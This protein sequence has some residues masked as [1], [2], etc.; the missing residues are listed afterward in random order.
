MV[1][2][3]VDIKTASIMR[4]WRASDYYEF[5]LQLRTTT[6]G[7]EV[8]F[9]ILDDMNDPAGLFA[10]VGTETPTGY[11]TLVDGALDEEHLTRWLTELAHRL[12]QAGV[13][14]S[15]DI[16]R[17][18]T[19]PKFVLF[20]RPQPTAFLALTLA[21]R[22]PETAPVHWSVSNEATVEVCDVAQDWLQPGGNK[23]LLQRGTFTIKTSD[24][25]KIA[26]LLCAATEDTQAAA[27]VYDDRAKRARAVSMY[28]LGQVSFQLV[29]GTEAWQERLAALRE[30]LLTFPHLL[31]QAFIRAG[32]A[33][34][35]GWAFEGLM[36][37]PTIR[38]SDFI[39]NRH[40][41]DRWVP[42]AHGIQILSDE[43]LARAN[44]LS[45]WNITD[46]GHSRHLVE[47][48]DLAPW[49]SELRP[50]P[51]TVEQARHDFGDMIVTQQEVEDNWPAWRPPRSRRQS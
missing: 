39:H 28:R 3:S 10:Q 31:D 42:D 19:K 40:L 16:T 23:V 15:L 5:W 1:D 2:G 34:P 45:R 6:P 7:A 35:M 29:D 27:T 11:V 49:Y 37:L 24:P 17:S 21:P 25:T 33:T 18:A 43:H 22:P 47:A 13:T 8:F 48:P 50:D 51:A 4:R 9:D 12:E 14:G 41:L 46:L 44:D 20:A 36:P 38:V 26:E 30:P 32:S